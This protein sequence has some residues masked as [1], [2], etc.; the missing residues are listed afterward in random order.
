MRRMGR[1]RAF[2]GHPLRQPVELAALL[3][4][5][6]VEGL[7]VDVQPPAARIEADS[8]LLAAALLNLLDNA[9]RH[10]AGH[11]SLHVDGQTLTLVND[12][13]PIDDAQR[14]ALQTALARQDDDGDAGPLGLG[15]RLADLVA[16]AHGGRLV[17]PP[18]AT[19]FAVRLELGAQNT[20]V[21]EPARAIP[22]SESLA[23][24]LRPPGAAQ[25]EGASAPFERPGGRG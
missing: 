1:E 25:P 19:G 10:G 13:R 15:L 5:L 9:V 7:E 20:D 4:R 18:A 3:A 16:H 2:A 8:D 11:A 22:R 17:L 14:Q 24:A 12:G 23:G 21:M 6:P